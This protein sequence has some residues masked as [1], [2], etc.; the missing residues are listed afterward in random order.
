[1]KGEKIHIE[2]SMIKIEMSKICIQIGNCWILEKYSL[3]EFM[4]MKII[5]SDD[6]N[7]YYSKKIQY[8]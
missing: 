4:I 8:I 6:Y 2:M 3:L 7:M 1:M 5:F